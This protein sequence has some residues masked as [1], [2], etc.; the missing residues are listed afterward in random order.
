MGLSLEF[1]NTVKI[2]FKTIFFFAKKRQM[3]FTF[4]SVMQTE[5]LQ[6]Y[7]TVLTGTI[8]FA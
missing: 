7:C 1:L 2:S 4:L 6:T 5:V 8:L 3:F